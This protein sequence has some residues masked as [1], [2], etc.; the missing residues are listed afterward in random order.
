PSARAARSAADVGFQLGAVEQHRID[1]E[2][3]ALGIRVLADG[4]LVIAEKALER[5]AIELA[6]G[7]GEQIEHP[8][9][10]RVNFERLALGAAENLS[11]GITG[12]GSVAARLLDH[13]LFRR[14]FDRGQLAF[15]VAEDE[16]EPTGV[17]GA[18]G[19]FDRA[20]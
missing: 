3:A 10:L 2:A 8:L 9:A 7:L 14:A 5:G 12:S 11:T 17:L 19:L 20:S 4:G 18:L 6:F 16:S 15:A 1:G 13:E